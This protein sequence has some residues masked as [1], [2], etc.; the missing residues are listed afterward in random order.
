MTA[1]LENGILVLRLPIQTPRPS[2]SGKTLIV[3]S[4][5]TTKLPVQVDGQTLYA[6]VNAWVKK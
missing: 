3:A 4:S 1:Q 5:G 2:A 6:S